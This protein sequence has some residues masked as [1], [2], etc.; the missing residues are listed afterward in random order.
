[1]GPDCAAGRQD[2]R[3][4]RPRAANE[5][6]SR[7]TVLRYL[8]DGSGLDPSFGGGIGIPAGMV[9][10]T[11]AGTN[12]AESAHRVGL[13]S[14]GKIVVLGKAPLT[15][16]GNA[17]DAAA[18]ARYHPDGT[19]DGTFGSGGKVLIPFG[20]DNAWPHAL[21]TAGDEDPRRG[22]MWHCGRARATERQWDTRQRIWCGW[23][24]HTCHRQQ[25]RERG[26]QGH[27]NRRFGQNRR[28]RGIKRRRARPPPECQWSAGHDV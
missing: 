9:R 4:R 15:G 5:T 21:G 16:K 26:Y 10:T 27:Q 14:D 17:K 25:E 7:F 3:R 20:N 1:M 23:K 2:C 24:G 19:L 13:Q 18:V 28:G 11:F 6:F 22:S 12:G 8:A